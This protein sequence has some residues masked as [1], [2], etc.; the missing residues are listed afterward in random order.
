MAKDD[1]DEKE[2]KKKGGKK[3]L[4]IIIIVAAVVVLGG[5]GVGAYFAFFAHSGEENAHPEPTPSAVVVAEAITVNLA[6]GHYLKIAI[7]LQTTT[8]AVEAVDTSK[9]LDIVISQFSN[10]E[11]AELS[12]N[13][14]REAEKAELT[15]KVVKAY[16]EEKLE[17]VMAV[18]F[19]EFVIQ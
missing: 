18:Y 17:Y 15:E 1:K 12:T 3:K 7:A 5:G 2:E 8:N 14:Q 16:T 6:D 19:T 10:L 13:K 11:V 9:A 4:L